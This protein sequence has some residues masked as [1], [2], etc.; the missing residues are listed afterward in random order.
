MRHNMK[1]LPR[2]RRKQ[3]KTNYEKR[4]SLLKSGK[5]RL[6]VRKTNK[7][8]IAQLIEYH[9]DGDKVVT[10]A[11]STDLEKHGWEGSYNNTPA[12]YLTGML[13]AE[14]AND[15]GIKEAV[16]DIGLNTPV[17]GARVF[18]VAKGANDAGLDVNVSEEIAPSEE[19]IEGNHIS[20]DMKKQF[21]KVK[22]AI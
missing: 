3:S 20:E 1:R 11:Y 12:A 14:K 21:E 13:I 15:A 6:V 19:R 8:I 5:P 18:A 17:K 2:K 7:K 22:E 9:P 16:L 4:L 10:S